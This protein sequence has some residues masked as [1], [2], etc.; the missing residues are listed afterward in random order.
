LINNREIPTITTN[1]FISN[2]SSMQKERERKRREERKR[3]EKRIIDTPLL[4]LII[5]DYAFIHTE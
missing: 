2:T 5:I 1:K 4:L 3:C